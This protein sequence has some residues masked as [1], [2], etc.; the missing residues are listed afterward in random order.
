MKAKQYL[1]PPPKI[2]KSLLKS[3]KAGDFFVL[4]KE[5]E[6]QLNDSQSLTIIIVENSSNIPVIRCDIEII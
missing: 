5:L 2:V 4:D 3:N 1:D 6:V